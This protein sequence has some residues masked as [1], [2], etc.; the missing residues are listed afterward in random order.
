MEVLSVQ[1]AV[2]HGTVGNNAAVPVLQCLGLTPLALHTVW[3]AHH[4]GHPGW[5][6]EVTAPTI[7]EPF[8]RYSLAAPHLN[9]TAV[10]SGYLGTA[11]QAELLARYLPAGHFY[12][13]DPVIGDTPGGQ[14][15]SDALVHA[16][17]EHLLPRATVLLPNPFELSLL[18]Q[19]PSH[20]I[21]EAIEAARTL[22]NA[23]P[24]LHI[25][26]VKG[27]RVAEELHLCTVTRDQF[28]R[29]QH[30]AVAYRVS[31]TGDAFSAAWLACYLQTGSL[32]VAL[33]YAA[34]FLYRAVRYTA[35]LQQREL[36]IWPELLWLREGIMRLRQTTL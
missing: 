4:K 11:A 24:A 5:F 2:L 31:G 22:L 16:Y 23:Y 12:A 28:T 3:Y 36:Q 17:H 33:T 30:P 34:E 21:P 6:G 19:Q 25:V 9:V 29:A 18:S 26:V 14:Y 15:V 20:S 1:S 10:L 27:I 13:C 32:H 8:L 7:F 35:Q